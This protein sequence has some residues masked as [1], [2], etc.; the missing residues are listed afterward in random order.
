[1]DLSDY[2]I[3]GPACD[4]IEKDEIKIK[5]RIETESKTET[6]T[7][8]ETESDVETKTWIKSRMDIDIEGDIVDDF[9]DADKNDPIELDESCQPQAVNDDETKESPMSD[10]SFDQGVRLQVPLRRSIRI[11]ERR[12]RQ[13]LQISIGSDIDKH[14]TSQENNDTPTISTGIY[15]EESSPNILGSIFVDG[16]RRSARNLHNTVDATYTRNR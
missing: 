6:E 7:E 2:E 12:E 11:A 8:T 1:M 14:I 9:A 4:I 3:D 13:K 5:V 16:R 10:L 15:S